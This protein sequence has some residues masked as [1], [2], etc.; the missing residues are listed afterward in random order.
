MQMNKRLLLIGTGS[1][2]YK[3]A[4]NLLLMG[5]DIYI[6]SKNKKNFYNF[7]KKIKKKIF[8]INNINKINFQNFEFILIANETHKRFKY[9][10]L[11]LKKNINIF[12]EKPFFC[13]KN[14]L[15]QLQN[16][17]R[18]FKKLLYFNY[19]LRFHPKILNI[20][21]NIKKKNVRLVNCVVG[22]DL[23]KWRKE[24]ITKESYFI[25]KTKGGGVILE[26]V[27]EINTLRYLFGDF[28]KI[29]TFKSNHKFYNVE[30]IAVSI[31]KIKNKNII[32]S[33]SQ[34]MIRSKYTRYIEYSIDNKIHKVDISNKKNN[35][36]KKSLDFFLKS[37]D[38]KNDFY[39]KEALKDFKDCIKMHNAEL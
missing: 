18:F 30:D 34:D 31:F 16:N 17:Y 13:S 7:K 12:C 27:H 14:E 3:H 28:E 32:G 5:Y 9:L 25:N 21:K 15:I 33:I 22:L 8:F 29:I 4:K 1:I 23:K 39:F 37:L 35:L 36:L 11:G 6:I 20:K 19:Q 10:K 26:L 2:A 38:K 24:K